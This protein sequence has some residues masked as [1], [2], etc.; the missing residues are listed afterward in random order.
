[1]AGK[2]SRQGKSRGQRK[3]KGVKKGKEKKSKGTRKE[4]V[5]GGL[6]NMSN[7]GL[8][9][10]VGVLWTPVGNGVTRKLARRDDVR[11][12][13]RLWFLTL[14]PLCHNASKR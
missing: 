10:S 4:T 7:V 11:W 2:A 6:S 13:H 8:N 1:M 3:G 14:D 5:D 9:R 12:T